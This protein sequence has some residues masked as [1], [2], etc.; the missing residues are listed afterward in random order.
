MKKDKNAITLIKSEIAAS[1]SEIE[2]NLTDIEKYKTKMA[3]MRENLR[4]L[5]IINVEKKIWIN[6]LKSSLSKLED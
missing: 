2:V 5:E 3:A 1:E 4:K 6:S